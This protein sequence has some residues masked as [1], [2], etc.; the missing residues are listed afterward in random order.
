MHNHVYNKPMRFTWNER[1]R[2]ANIK[3]HGIDFTDVYKK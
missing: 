1:K 2:I 3:K